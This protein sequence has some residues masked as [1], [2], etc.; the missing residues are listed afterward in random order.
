[1]AKLKASAT[2][3]R[4]SSNATH[5]AKERG[6]AA[7]LLVVALMAV[8]MVVPTV[9]VSQ[10]LIEAPPMIHVDLLANA[11]VTAQSGL[12]LFEAAVDQDPLAL[13]DFPSPSTS[14]IWPKKECQS[15][16][17][18]TGW[19][20]ISKGT[21]L[22]GHPWEEVRVA[23]TKLPQG[24]T[25][26]VVTVFAEGR[27]GIPGHWTCDEEKM[28]ID[29]TG[30]VLNGPA[31]GQWKSYA[32]PSWAKY[33]YASLAGAE[34]EGCNL[35]NQ[36]VTPSPCAYSYNHELPTAGK[37]AEFFTALP[38]PTRGGLIG[39]GV[40]AHL[41]ADQSMPTGQ[42]PAQD[43]GVFGHGGESGW[44][45][46][47]DSG[48]VGWLATE[49]GGQD[50]T[51]SFPGG[52]ATIV[53]WCPAPTTPTNPTCD[54]TT[55]GAQVLAVAGG[56]GGSGSDGTSLNLLKSTIY[57][58]GNGGNGGTTFLQVS[59][60][61]GNWATCD[62][63]GGC[64]A[65]GAPGSP[66]GGIPLVGPAGGTGGSGGATPT[67][68]LA[69]SLDGQPPTPIT[70]ACNINIS[71]FGLNFGS[72]TIPYSGGGGGGG[73]QGGSQ[74][75]AGHKGFLNLFCDAISG[76][77]GGGGGSSYIEQGAS[78]MAM[79]SSDSA[80]ELAKPNPNSQGFAQL[81]LSST[82]P[83]STSSLT[84]IPAQSS[85]TL[86]HK[87]LAPYPRAQDVAVLLKG[88]SGYSNSDATG[89]AG[90]AFP[91]LIQLPPDSYLVASC[92]PGGTGGD[93]TASTPAPSGQGGSGTV[94]CY[95]T[96]LVPCS[97]P[98][99]ILAVAGGGGG[100]GDQGD[101]GGSV[102]ACLWGCLSGDIGPIST[103]FHAGQGGN[104]GIPF[105]PP[106]LDK[107]YSTSQNT[108][109]TWQQG[110][111]GTP[112]NIA[113]TSSGQLCLPSFF[114]ISGPC[115]SISVSSQPG[116]T[117]GYLPSGS[118]PQP[119]APA[120]QAAACDVFEYQG[121]SYEL[122]SGGGG[123]GGGYAG[124]QAGTSGTTSCNPGSIL[125]LSW[126]YGW[127]NPGGGGG[128]GSSWEGGALGTGI[129]W[130]NPAPAPSQ[131]S[132]GQTSS[133]PGGA[134]V[135][136][137]WPAKTLTGLSVIASAPVGSISW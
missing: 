20:V 96:S 84:A 74:G 86:P 11:R 49:L 80:I 5:F 102:Q 30:S 113:A 93:G 25:T 91:V 37:G 72:A 105:G 24:A 137:S 34:G 117:G 38:L 29:V 1:M 44:T 88:Q 100:A 55:P 4:R 65:Q 90:A 110:T 89:G 108:Y 112:G 64:S 33:A 59:P 16:P 124:G 107:N 97:S 83:F 122:D 121:P 35:V 125:G 104:A 53:L 129:G 56:G 46:P 111:T 131:V 130:R 52:G 76:S 109:P 54:P 67:G 8:F 28:R 70:K 60:A 50:P 21:S 13:Q 43:P 23:A 132:P 99:S 57:P 45:P 103:F 15:N 116:G 135:L 9:A 48:F 77:G 7:I 19:Q 134:V 41:P 66:G 82:S 39:I 133:S 123:G 136:G 127:G 61:A 22:T 78:L 2:H 42:D 31:P 51:A 3:A 63:P 101:A 75:T 92:E 40:G 58:G 6:Q 87:L 18:Q 106:G 17:T 26:G 114:S 32:L 69:S 94:L 14:S 10:A 68:P 73:Y 36:A 119:G 79:S 81:W 85:C 98:N 95:S 27:S 115:F 118:G 62:S 126:I 12:Q 71:L 120:N 128:G 47:E